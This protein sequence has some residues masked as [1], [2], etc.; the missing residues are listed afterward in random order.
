MTRSELRAFERA[1]GAKRHVAMF[2][3]YFYRDEHP[4]TW[5]H[6]PKMA[7]LELARDQMAAFHKTIKG[8]VYG[9][10]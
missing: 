3:C 2:D 8:V 9:S 5:M 1:I 10:R 6:D 4:R 7:E